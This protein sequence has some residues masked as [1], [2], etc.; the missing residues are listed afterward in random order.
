MTDLEALETAPEEKSGWRKRGLLSGIQAALRMQGVIRKLS[1]LS[2]R[3]AREE[4]FASQLDPELRDK[5]DTLG[6]KCFQ[7]QSL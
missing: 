2:D 7:H 4:T 1:S 6:E 5:L 3:S